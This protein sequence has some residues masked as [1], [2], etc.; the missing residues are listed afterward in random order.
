DSPARFLPSA[1][2]QGARLA[3][4]PA[5]ELLA[6][7][8][9]AATEDL[10]LKSDRLTPFL[11][12][13][14]AAR[15]AGPV[16][17]QSLAGTSFALA[18]DSMLHETP[19]GWRALLPLRADPTGTIRLDPELLRRTLAAA[20]APGGVSVRFLDVKRESDGLYADYLREAIGLSLIGLAAI[21]AVL[22]LA[23]RSP[24]RVLRVMLPLIASVLVVVAGLVLA[25]ESLILLHLVGLLLVVAVGSNYALFFVRAGE[26]AAGPSPR[27][28][29]SLL[30]ANLTTLAGFGLLATS[31]VPVLYA[32]GV[33]VGP[34]AVLALLF[35]AMLNTRARVGSKT[36]NED[37]E[38][39]S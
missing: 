36:R 21:V 20:R 17:A 27:T 4:L 35:A 6:E 1:S 2:T 5:P 39:S 3:S 29:A 19:S 32:I 13:V 11:D 16:T 8:L 7:R 28:L 18:V 26:D 12:D 23:L 38:P 9:A 14:A 15:S 31:S 33:T 34:G 37:G 22:G 10:P 25:G 30:F 24:Q